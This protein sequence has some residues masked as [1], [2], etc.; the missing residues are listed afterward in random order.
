MTVS[1]V[2]CLRMVH[3]TVQRGSVNQSAMLS[4]PTLVATKAN[5]VQSAMSM[6]PI[7]AAT[8]ASAV[9]REGRR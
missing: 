2:K 6:I 5:A 9:K 8:G 1:V 3:W 7:Q 4:I